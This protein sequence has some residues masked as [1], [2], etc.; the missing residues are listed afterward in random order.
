M[1]TNLIFF[2]FL[3]LVGILIFPIFVVGCASK[4]QIIWEESKPEPTWITQLKSDNEYFYYRGSSVKAES[5]ESG[6][7]AARE[8]AY[9][10]VAEYLFTELKSEYVGEI[11][12]FEQS[13]KDSIQARSSAMVK[14]AEVMDSYYKKMKRVE[15]D[16][17][18]ERYD[19][20]V[21]VRY[22][23]KE[24]E[25]ERLRQ[26]QE[27]YQNVMSALALYQKAK[28]FLINGEYFE[29]RRFS[30]DALL[31]L[32][33]VK[34]NVSLG[35]SEIVNH[36][37][38]SVLV[39]TLQEDALRSLH[40]III[41]VKEPPG[42]RGNNA[43]GFSLQ[44]IS[45]LSKHG[46][47]GIE[48]SLALSGRAEMVVSATSEVSMKDVSGIRELGAGLALVGRVSPIYRST[49]MGQH[50]ID[51]EGA[52]R[53]LRVDSGDTLLTFSINGRGQDREKSQAERR[54]LEEAGREAG[55]YL[56]KELLAIERR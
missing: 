47:S 50:L 5:L 55:E 8:N 36:H 51:A 22:P 4:A 49:V 48:P 52:L 9:S 25:A 18:L 24:A 39:K 6:E 11:T 44:L 31:L 21:L 34:G 13:H 23:K 32:E 53:L 37:E 43:S 30:R 17:V 3:R 29:A 46:F 38:L 42:G 12:D 14:K 40:R 20:Y 16:H 27:A 56:V 35:K 28:A 41:F 33:H 2:V 45:V 19:V 1:F 54:A 15:G 26:E 7:S 10:Q